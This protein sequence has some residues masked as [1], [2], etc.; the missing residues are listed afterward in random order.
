MSYIRI[1]ETPDKLEIFDSGKCVIFNL[2]RDDKLRKFGVYH[3]EIREI[4]NWYL[5]DTNSD[6]FYNP[7]IG[8]EL[9]FI[10]DEPKLELTLRREDFR[11]QHD[12]SFLIYVSTWEAF[13]YNYIKQETKHNKWRRFKYYL[14]NKL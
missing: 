2:Y 8:I 14:T 9:P 5:N 7:E 12:I 3:S 11:I 10:E 4:I 1:T 13:V 6:Y